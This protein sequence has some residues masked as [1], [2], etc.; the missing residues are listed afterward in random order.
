GMSAVLNFG[1]NTNDTMTINDPDR[2]DVE[3]VYTAAP[4]LFSD[5]AIELRLSSNPENRF[6]WM[7][8]ANSYDGQFDAHTNGSVNY[9]VANLPGSP[10]PTLMVQNAPPNRDGEIAEVRGVFASFDFDITKQLTLSAE[11]RYQKDSAQLQAPVVAGVAAPAAAEF[12][13]TMPR[14]ILKWQPSES[15]NLYANWAKGALPGQFNS[16]YINPPNPP[17]GTSDVAFVRQ[18]IEAVFPGVSELAPSPELTSIE[19]G[20]KQRL[21]NDRVE[22]SVAVYDMKWEK[23]LSGSALTV[24][25]R[26]GVGAPTLILTGVL[27]PGDSKIQGLEFEG[28]ARLTE[29][30]DVNLRFDT[31][32]AEYTKFFDPFVQQLTGNSSN[33][34][35]FDGNALP[36]I[37]KTTGSIATSW[38]DQLNADWEWYV[39]GEAAYT[40]RAWDSAANIVQTDAYTRVNLRLGF[41]KEGF[42][43]ELYCKNCANDKSWDYG[44][45][46]VSF[47]EPG[48][49]LLV[50]L[51]LTPATTN[52]Q[53][54]IIVQ[55]PDKRVF[56]LRFRYEFN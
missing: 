5:R 55:P 11:G 10:I 51:P 35:R 31:K 30:W 40:G 17:G 7:I 18:Q 12:T 39:R 54:G 41:E 50:P 32:K 48:G 27:I 20:L 56:G 15:L 28:T 47:R 19:F 29:N 33:G 8:G 26:P 2:S 43:T 4:A 22:Y 9:T 21:W 36:R 46:S 3:N 45:R 42:L 37:P 1:R 14:V 34:V 23:M 52:F 38:R 6:R 24:A 13:D 25:A 44:F 49:S 53:Q 16:Q